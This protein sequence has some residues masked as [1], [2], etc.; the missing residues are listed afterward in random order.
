MVEKLAPRLQGIILT[1]LLSV[2]AAKYHVS[3]ACTA[4]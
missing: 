1:W 3:F 2:V 4:F